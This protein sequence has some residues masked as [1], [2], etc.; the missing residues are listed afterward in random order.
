V[1]EAAAPIADEECV[2]LRG[3]IARSASPELA[4]AARDA[5]D[6]TEHPL[7]AKLLTA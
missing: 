3:R 6:A 2:V 5:L 4:A 1:I 7:A